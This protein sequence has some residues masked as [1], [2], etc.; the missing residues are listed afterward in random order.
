[1]AEM[2]ISRAARRVA[3]GK[4]CA[5]GPVQISLRTVNEMLFSSKGNPTALLQVNITTSNYS[6]SLQAV[7]IFRPGVRKRC[8]KKGVCVHVCVCMPLWEGVSG[9]CR[10]ILTRT[11]AASR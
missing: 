6:R 11:A 8:K 10:G 3:R 7:R 4:K 9:G 5:F 1:M 2:I